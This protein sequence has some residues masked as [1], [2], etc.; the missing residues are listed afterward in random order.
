MAMYRLDFSKAFH[1]EMLLGFY[2]G[3][4][5]CFVLAIVF[6]RM[7]W[8][9]RPGESIAVGFCA[10]FSNTV[11]L[12]LPIAERAFGGAIA[13]PVFG[14]IALHASLLYAVGMTSMEL[15]RR[16]GRRLG[17]TLKAAFTSIAA[18]P[19]MIGILAGLAANF[20]GLDLPEPV[21]TPIAML[22]ATGIPVSLIGIGM[23]LNRYAIKT[24]L[25][26]SLMVSTLALIVH[27]AITFALTRWVFDLPVI[28]VQA[29]VLLAAM[30]PGMNVYIFASLYNRAVA[31]SASVIITA[32]V[33]A[34]GTISFWLL[35]LQGL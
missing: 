13:A 18:N 8:K 17:E 4:F 30:P 23:V 22:A 10:V 16:D 27:P 14:V 12:G 32:N 25:A 20:F 11:L 29:A 33:L 24:E 7:I 19:L 5:S 31:L 34:I 21:E 35:V 28:Y 15:A 26:E 6:A 3:A 1:L 2:I 9:R